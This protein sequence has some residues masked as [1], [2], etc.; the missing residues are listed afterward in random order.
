MNDYIHD[1]DFNDISK[2]RKEV[3]ELKRNLKEYVQSLRKYRNGLEIRTLKGGGAVVDLLSMFSSLIPWFINLLKDWIKNFPNGDII[4]KSLDNLDE[5]STNLKAL[6]NIF[7]SWEKRTKFNNVLFGQLKTIAYFWNSTLNLIVSQNY[8]FD[9][10]TKAAA[11]F[12]NEITNRPVTKFGDH[13]QKALDEYKENEKLKKVSKDFRDLIKYP[14]KLIPK[15]SEIFIKYIIGP[16]IPGLTYYNSIE[17]MADILLNMSEK[18]LDFV[19]SI[20]EMV[21]KQTKCNSG[22]THISMQNDNDCMYIG[23]D[24]VIGLDILLPFWNSSH[25]KSI[26]EKANKLIPPVD[27]E[28][29]DQLLKIFIRLFIKLIIHSEMIDI[30]KFLNPSALKQFIELR[31]AVIIAEKISTNPLLLGAVPFQ[32]PTIED[33]LFKFVK[34]FIDK[35]TDAKVTNIVE[36]LR[37]SPKT[38]KE[39]IEVLMNITKTRDAPTAP[40]VPNAHDTTAHDTT[41]HDT[42]AHA[43]ASFGGYRK[44]TRKRTKKRTKRSKKNTRKC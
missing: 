13:R 41:A 1:F 25:G 5:A 6:G 43:A 14:P 38:V 2:K 42:T 23:D 36:L 11:K 3:I 29:N 44:N 19:K 31:K 37:G 33:E 22:S 24:K 21:G 32:I 17:A 4:I 27:I 10:E 35:D 20:L 15:A 28:N 18:L 16:L 30:V 40:S 34:K 12:T 9:D 39:I 8:V 7:S 26:I